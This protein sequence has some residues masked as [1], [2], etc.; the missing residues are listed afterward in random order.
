MVVFLKY[1]KVKLIFEKKITFLSYFYFHK[2]EKKS[3]FIF[4]INKNIEKVC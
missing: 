3:I 4:K 1:F 2:F